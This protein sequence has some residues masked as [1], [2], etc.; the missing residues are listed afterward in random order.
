MNIL[1]ILDYYA[2]VAGDICHENSHVIRSHAECLKALEILKYQTSGSFWT[3]QYDQI[4]TGCSIKETDMTP[5]FETSPNG[6]GKG[7]NDL[8]PICKSPLATYFDENQYYAGIEGGVCYD[9]SVVIRSQEEC[10][11]A[12]TKLGFQASA[13]YYKGKYDSIPSGCSFGKDNMKP[14]FETSTSGLG[15]GR[16]DLIPI[17][18]R[19]KNIGNFY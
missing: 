18:S 2:K 11:Y 5:H 8:I 3:G 17:C 14:H 4:P 10:T 16:G 7:R 1:S 19:P 12:I 6:L 13:D 15:K 9:G